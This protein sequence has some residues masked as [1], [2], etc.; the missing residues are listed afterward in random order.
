MENLFHQHTLLKAYVT[1]PPRSEESLNTWLRDLVTAVGM[2]IC[3]EPRSFYVSEPGNEGLT[4]QVGLCTSHAAIHVW[5]H[6]EP[7]M[8][9]MD[10][11]SCRA[12]EPKTL[13]DLV[14]RWGLL[15]Y[16]MMEIDRNDGFKVVGHSL[17][18]NKS[19]G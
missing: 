18:S 11:Y 13:V 7:A 9:Q 12:Y 15:S 8:I 4:G 16:E 6:E 3:I 10:L 14:A 2:K 19:L 1:T 5:D 17:W